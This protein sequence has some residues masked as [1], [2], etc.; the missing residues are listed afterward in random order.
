MLNAITLGVSELQTLDVP[1]TEEEI[2]ERRLQRSKYE[3]AL[4]EVKEK[5]SEFKAKIEYDLNIE[6]NKPKLKEI[7]KELR[8]KCK[9]VKLKVVE[10]P[11]PENGTVDIVAAEDACGYASGETIKIRPMTMR[12]RVEFGATLSRKQSQFG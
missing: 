3:E 8:T 1:L 5:V 12:E 9:V 2:V 11:D 7:K 10:N 4:D 6:S